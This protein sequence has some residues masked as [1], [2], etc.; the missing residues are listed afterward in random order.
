MS[1]LKELSEKDKKWI[2]YAFSVCRDYDLS[3][4]LV[5]DAYLKVV[6]FKECNDAGF[7]KIIKNQF[8]DYIKRQNK[9]TE[10]IE[11]FYNSDDNSITDYELRVLNRFY[12]LPEITQELIRNKADQSFR[13]LE[14]NYGINFLKVRRDIN[15]AIK[16]I[17]DEKK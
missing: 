11:T 14:E 1:I 13:D 15:K 12:K 2:K 10:L 8:L 6:D 17:T 5:Q 3:K 4:D 7:K 16:Q 9:Q